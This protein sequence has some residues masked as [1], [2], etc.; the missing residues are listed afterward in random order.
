MAGPDAPEP[1]CAAPSPQPLS[2][3]ERGFLP[4]LQFFL[5]PLQFFLPPLQFFLPPLQFLMSCGNFP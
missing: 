5:P 3:W 2:R 1:G 4:P